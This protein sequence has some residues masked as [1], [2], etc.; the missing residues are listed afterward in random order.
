MTEKKNVRIIAFVGLPGTG[1]SAA[2]SYLTEQNIPKVSF[3]DI[4]MKAVSEA[5]LD[6][7]QENE[8]EVRE[9]L[10]L[11]PSGDKALAQVISEIQKLIDSGQHRI[12]LDGLGSWESYK[13]LKHEFPGNVTV[14]AFT[15]QKYIRYR[16]L[17]QRESNPLPEPLVDA[18]DYD[19]I[20][21]LNKGGVIAM[22]DFYIFDNGSLE[23]LHTQID[24][25]LRQLEF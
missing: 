18:R 6:P 19:E 4:V 13:K 2:T 1:K 21:T 12:V 14:V 22:A 5:A 9:K 23:Q 8:R 16:R 10:R 7:T 20:E 24:D 11:D 3:G 15:A 17:A 25:L